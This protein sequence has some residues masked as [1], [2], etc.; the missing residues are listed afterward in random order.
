MSSQVINFVAGGGKTTYSRKLMLEKEDGL[1]LAFTKSVVKEMRDTGI[2]SMTISSLF[3]SYILPKMFSFIPIVANGAS[4]KYNEKNTLDRI[5]LGN[6]KISNDGKLCNKT[7][8]IPVN[9]ET[10][11]KTLHSSPNFTN[12]QFL[13]RI[14]STS[15]VLLDD[16]QR[17][18]L[19]W[20]VIKNYPEVVL[21]L[22]G[23]RFKYIIIDEAQDIKPGFMEDFAKLLLKSN[24][25]LVLLGDP[26]QN[27]NGGSEWFGN[28]A[29]TDQA[30]KTY[31]CPDNNCSWIRDNL[32]ID[33]KGN[34]TVS[35]CQKIETISLDNYDD[36]S[37]FLLYSQSSPTVKDSIDK[38]SGPKDTIRSAKGST[39]DMD[40]VI[41][42]KTM[43]SRNLYT[44]ITRTTK[45][46]YF[47]I[48]RINV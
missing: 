23:R 11:N 45:N 48:E 1:Y 6:I 40:I 21:D 33:I 20:Y 41:L 44:A 18:S 14:F 39:I 28:L 5:S 25:E 47:T 10:S 42:G 16:G 46:A 43:N 9:L 15:S 36:G 32:M 37:R 31:R 19:S 17:D 34:K 4:I 13:R 29:T 27:I 38:W 24:I 3:F 30:N 26:R 22:L 12:G 35:V 7:N 8:L 2:L